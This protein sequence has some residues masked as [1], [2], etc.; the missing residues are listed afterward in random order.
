MERRNDPGDGSLPGSWYACTLTQGGA[1][2]NPTYASEVLA[3]P[4]EPNSPPP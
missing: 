1:L 3:T 4:D 2:V